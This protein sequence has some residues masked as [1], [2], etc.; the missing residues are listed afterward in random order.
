[1]LIRHL[2]RG[3]ISNRLQYA[4]WLLVAVRLIVPISAQIYLSLGEIDEFR[5]MDLVKRL[6]GD[7][8]D[9]TEHLEQPL[10]FT[11]NL[12]SMGGA[13][14][15][16]KM[17]GEEISYL[18]EADGPTSIFLAGSVGFTWLDLLRWIW[19]GGM[20]VMAVWMA[21]VNLRFCRKLHRER[22]KFLLP[23][24]VTGRLHSKVL[25]SL[26]R[27]RVYTLEELVS[28]CL[29]GVPGLEAVYLPEAVTQ[30][31]DRLCHVLTHEICHKR[32]GDGFWSL[33][34]N[35]LLVCYWF[36]PLVWVA[37]VLSRRDCELACDEGAL[38]L[39]GEQERISY[40]KTL[41]SIIAGRG[42][43][44]DFAC[45][46]TTMTGSGRSV[47]ER[48][49]CIAEK[50]RVLGAAAAA[51]LILITAASLLVFT[52]S[53]QFTGGIW[54]SGTIY[55]MT[56]DKRIMLPDSIAGISGY[57]GEE[58]NHKNLIV[59][60][61]ASDQEVGR[62][63]TVSFE[64]A[65]ALV[66]AGRSVVPL[67]TYGKNGQLREYMGLAAQQVT[68]HG[69]FPSEEDEV[70]T[71]DGA[72]QTETK[73]ES[74]IKRSEKDP[75]AFD[76]RTEWEEDE[77]Y[78]SAKKPFA[79]DGKNEWGIEEPQQVEQ[80]AE[81]AQSSVA[82]T[83]SNI[84]ESTT[85]IISDEMADPDTAGEEAATYLPEASNPEADGS[86]VYLPEEPGTETDGST[87][88]LP[89]EPGT[90]TDGSTVYLPEETITTTYYPYNTGLTDC[91]IYLTADH[92]RVKDRDL[93]EMRYIDDE[94]KAAAA[95][96]I[97]TDINRDI[98]EKTF[99]SL[100]ERKTQYLGDA[101]AV[102]ALVN[103]LPF[104][105]GIS[106][107]GTE[108]TTAASRK[109]SL[110]ILCDLTA[111]EQDML[112]VNHD[113]LRFDGVMLFATIENLEEC[114]FAV[115]GEDGSLLEEMVY[116]RAELTEWIGVESLWQD[117]EGEK[118]QTWLKD[119]HQR[120]LK[121]LYWTLD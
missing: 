106:Y 71:E 89:E 27:G 7:Y 37:A 73:R 39:L 38:L 90:E 42:K 9:I 77:S 98:T 8:G 11:M 56:E 12:D 75:F 109:K 120:V 34:R 101:S 115:M 5:I 96:V 43:L 113:V 58:G 48:I 59:Y 69:Y 86:T 53:P 28:P 23:E 66:D 85:Y 107:K 49:R 84:E 45:T 52:K 25:A 88:Y 15:A 74:S 72:P 30:E 46:A 4:L 21:A 32:H 10:S 3:R 61:V 33:L 64:E 16:E 87:V 78:E 110:R 54:D 36:H 22:R 2:F 91:Y 1:M 114:V 17:L 14:I 19:F 35:A 57:T 40:G 20:G 100:A 117:L 55:V 76:G 18:D 29:Y 80:E 70:D 24:G 111:S 102:V 121:S 105:E 44:S 116:D 119:L 50:P 108:L 68:Q 62:F 103:T 104:P 67:G 13:W 51:V 92:S 97:V 31:E 60:Q 81:H 79:F 65:A 41:L 83:D 47:K 112:Y 6:E 118:L 94:L 93:E 26:R 63:C 99:E 95:A 82:G